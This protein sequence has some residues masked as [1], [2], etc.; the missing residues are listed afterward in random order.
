MAQKYVST[1]PRP[2]CTGSAKV[3]G[4]AMGDMTTFTG[5]TVNGNFPLPAALG[6]S[7]HCP[8][9]QASKPAVSQVSKPAPCSLT[10]DA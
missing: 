1:I 10:T 5:P 6:A 8:V 2:Q 4:T 7:W 9:A 3:S